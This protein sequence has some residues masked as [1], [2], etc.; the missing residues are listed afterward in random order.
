M[1]WRA[2]CNNKPILIFWNNETTNFVR[3]TDKRINFGNVTT[4]YNTNTVK[5]VEY[6]HRPANKYLVFS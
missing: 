5:Y 1:I 2:D 6:W 4:F 3:P